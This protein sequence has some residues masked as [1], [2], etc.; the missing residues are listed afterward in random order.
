MNAGYVDAATLDMGLRKYML[1]IYNYMAS[2]VMLS[3]IVA[4]LFVQSGIAAQVFV[5][6]LRWLIVLAPL[7]FVFAMSAGM[8]GCRP[9]R[10]RPASGALPWRWG[11]R[12]PRCCWFT[13]GLRSR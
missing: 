7:G 11:F 5:T 8:G 1:S 4:L 13:P 10:L 2:A 6:P 12:S 3:G 9:A